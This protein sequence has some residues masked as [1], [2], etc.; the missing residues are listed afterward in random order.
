MYHSHSFHAVDADDIY[1]VFPFRI[2]V[3]DHIERVNLPLESQD[4]VDAIDNVEVY[5]I[6]SGEGQRCSK[7]RPIGINDDLHFVFVEP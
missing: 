3:C 6:V 5:L 1:N 2:A 7:G 4:S